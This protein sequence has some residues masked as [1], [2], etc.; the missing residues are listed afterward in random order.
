[1]ASSSSG[2]ATG[3]LPITKRLAISRNMAA[4]LA[5]RPA[6]YTGFPPT[7]W[8]RLPCSNEDPTAVIACGRNM[9][10]YWLLDSP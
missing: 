10:P 6:R 4:R 3:W 7:R 2:Y 8:L 5:H 9:A 1:V